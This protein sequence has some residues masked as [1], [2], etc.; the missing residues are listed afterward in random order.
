MGW[1]G[2]GVSNLA[3]VAELGTKGEVA[4]VRERK[5]L[6]QRQEVARV[7][8]LAAAR[9]RSQR[10]RALVHSSRAQD[11]EARFTSA[12]WLYRQQSRAGK[13]LSVK[14]LGFTDSSPALARRREGA[15][16]GASVGGAP[17]REPDRGCSRATRRASSAQARPE[18]ARGRG[19][20]DL[21]ES[22]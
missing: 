4:R 14:P 7:R 17:R 18:R 20:E 21:S 9:V 19:R 16:A 1:A 2:G 12:T 5:H 11:G 15:G 3:R 13:V 22:E 10:R 6:A 8:H